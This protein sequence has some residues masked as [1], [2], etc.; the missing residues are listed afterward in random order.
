MNY[1]FI[2]ASK[3]DVEKK[4]FECLYEN[5]LSISRTKFDI[6]ALQAELQAHVAESF[7]V[8]RIQNLNN[9]SSDFLTKVRLC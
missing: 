2:F 4:Y 7:K 3:V 1:A 5:P 9:Y 8:A 6:F